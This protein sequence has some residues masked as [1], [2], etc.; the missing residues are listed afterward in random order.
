[1]EV[2]A[3]PAPRVTFPPKRDR[4]MPGPGRGGASPAKAGRAGKGPW[5]GVSP[6]KDRPRGPQ[7]PP[8]RE[9]DAVR[10]GRSVAFGQIVSSHL[11]SGERV[12]ERGGDRNPVADK[13][14]QSQR[15]AAPSERASASVVERERERERERAGSGSGRVPPPVPPP[16]RRPK[17]KTLVTP[18]QSAFLALEQEMA[19]NLEREREKERE[20]RLEKEREFE[21]ARQLDRERERGRGRERERERDMPRDGPRGYR[22]G[23]SRR[24]PYAPEN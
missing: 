21:K 16:E 7:A 23:M 8:K 22:G 12:A 15:L 3:D 24:G 19:A 11:S 2:F 4:D 20:K 1:G 18:E 14:D 10:K 13:R 5:S 6:A 9:M 17:P